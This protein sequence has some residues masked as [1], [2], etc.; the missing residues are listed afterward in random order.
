MVI[1]TGSLWIGNQRGSG[2]FYQVITLAAKIQATEVLADYAE[3]ALL[4]S[5]ELRARSWLWY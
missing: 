1:G 2:E 5:N 4:V 3:L